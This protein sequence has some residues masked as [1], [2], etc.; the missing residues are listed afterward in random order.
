MIREFPSAQALS[1]WF[2]APP[3]SA[4]LAA[5]QP[6]ID[7]V[8]A[9]LHGRYLLQVG[10]DARRSL[11]AASPVS[12]RWLLTP[13]WQ[14]G[15][16]ADTLVGHPAELPIDSQCLDVVVLHHALD[17]N[18]SPHQVVREAARVLRPGGHLLVLG[19]NPLSLWG[20][21]RMLKPRRRRT[22]WQQGHFV[23]HHR[24]LD[25][26][27]LLQLTELRSQSG[28]FLPPFKTCSR[29]ALW[30]QAL[31]KKALPKNGAFYLTLARKDTPG[32]TPL[33]HKKRQ[34]PFITL[35]VTKPATTRGQARE[36][37]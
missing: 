21:L 1:D 6:L 31:G 22:L 26:M 8:L 2:A 4:L 9:D 19:F 15:Q 33:A 24:V 37:R 32:M 17:F 16:P 34:R 36:S 11:V 18:A 5:Q 25:W 30:L 35:P 13:A 12:H 27:H 7:Q 20:G 29:R 10:A 3:G 28:F 23:S 14:A